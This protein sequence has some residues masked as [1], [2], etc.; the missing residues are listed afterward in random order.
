[1]SSIQTRKIEILGSHGG[2]DVFISETYLLISPNGV[3]TQ[4]TN[5]D[6]YW[7]DAGTFCSVMYLYSVQLKICIACPHIKLQSPFLLFLLLC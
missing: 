7:L 3:T 5:I 6:K 1:M 4:K 2:E